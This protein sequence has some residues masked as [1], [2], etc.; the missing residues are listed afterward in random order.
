MHNNP[1]F[2]SISLSSQLFLMHCWFNKY[3]TPSLLY[4]HGS[5]E[6]MQEHMAHH[7]HSAFRGWVLLGVPSPLSSL[8]LCSV[9]QRLLLSNQSPFPLFFLFKSTPK[10]TC[11]YC[12]CTAGILSAV[13]ICMG[14]TTHHFFYKR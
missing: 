2:L 9:Q 1:L 13:C 3:T 4:L 12:T 10:W 5:R 7:F 6:D 11:I 14:K 8:L